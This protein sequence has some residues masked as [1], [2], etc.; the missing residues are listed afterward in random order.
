MSATPLDDVFA[1]THQ[2]V[3]NP[4]IRASLRDAFMLGASA[5]ENVSK[6]R[7]GQDVE[8][9]VAACV[10]AQAELQAWADQM[11]AR[12]KVKRGASN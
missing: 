5:F 8:D 3:V 9:A 4:E 7:E 2:N 6:V 1:L 10:A 12:A 11:E